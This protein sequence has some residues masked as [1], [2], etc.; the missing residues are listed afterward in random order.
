M[1]RKE[2]AVMVM[3]MRSREPVEMVE[4][5][6]AELVNPCDDHT[7]CKDHSTCCFNKRSEKWVCCPLPK[8][9]THNNHD[10]SNTSCT[11]TTSRTAQPQNG[12]KKKT[13]DGNLEK[14][15]RYGSEAFP[16]SAGGFSHVSI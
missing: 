9:S 16:L 5:A 3:A 14:P 1:W 8:V 4:E 6:G 2:P 11:S 12:Y 10:E 13:A 7:T 15:L